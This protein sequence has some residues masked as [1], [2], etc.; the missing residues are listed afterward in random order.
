MID[1]AIRNGWLIDGTGGVRHRADIGIQGEQVVEIGRVST[2]RIEIDAT[3]QVVSPGFIDPHSHSDFTLHANRESH[4]SIRQGVTTEIVGNCGFTNAPLSDQSALAAQARMRSFTYEGPIDWRTFGEYLENI[5]SGGITANIALFV[6]HNAIRT[7]AGLLGDEEVTDSHLRTMASL[8]A[9]AM[10]S[11]AIGMSTGLEYT[12]GIF[13]TPR[14]LQ[15]LAK[16]LGKHDGIYTSHI[17]NRDSRIFESVQELIDLAKIGGIS[18]QISHLNVRHDTNAPERAWER[19]VEMMKKAQSEGFDIE[20]DTTPFKH[21]IGKMTGILPRWLIDE[22]YTEVAK[23]L[24]DNLVRDRLRGDCDRYWRFIHKGQW[25]RVLLQSSPHL[26]E[27]NG[28][29]FPEIAKLHKKDEWDCFFDILQASGPEMDDLILVGEL[30]TEEHLAEMVSHP[31]F[32]LGVDGYTSVDKGPLSEVTMSQHPYSGHIEYLAHHVREM[33]TIS[34]ETAIHKMAAKPAK[35]FGIKKRGVLKEGNF[36]DIV[37]FDPANV[38]TKSTVQ[39][40]RAYPEGI[41]LVVVNGAIAVKNGEHSGS[42][43]GKVLRRS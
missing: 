18:A 16:E 36:A 15:Y 22:G 32:S 42:K 26:P 10:D 34:L 23:A 14:E 38:R 4:S 2:A 40:P 1:L 6:G 37:V 7:A 8:L 28:L 19:A 13:G 30:F 43:T 41:Q 3:D 29:T 5:E 25:N 31:D 9:E 17:R 12:P 24:K 33:K 11:G 39:Q 20:A 35:R 27:Y 21:G